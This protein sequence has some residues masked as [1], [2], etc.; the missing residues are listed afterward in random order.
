MLERTLICFGERAVHHGEA[1]EAKSVTMEKVEELLKVTVEVLGKERK[2]E[3]SLGM[4]GH[5]EVKYGKSTEA[6]WKEYMK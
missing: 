5:E 3:R 2:K 4:R 1:N 6:E